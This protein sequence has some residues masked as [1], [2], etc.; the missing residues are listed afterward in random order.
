VLGKCGKKGNHF[1][2]KSKCDCGE[3][4][5]IAGPNLTSGNTK[6]CGCFRVEATIKRNFK[7]G[8]NTKTSA[9]Y[10][11][12]AGIKSRIYNK[13]NAKYGVYGGRGIKLCTRWERFENFLSDM[14]KKPEGMSIDRI[15]NNKGYYRKNCR[16]ATSKQQARNTSRT[17]RIMYKGKKKSLVDWCDELGLS[18]GIVSQ[19]INK[20]GWTVNR[21]FT[22]KRPPRSTS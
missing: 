14:G 6:S 16:W 19:R 3:I 13:K 15:D 20:L 9:E 5:H 4:V 21:A 11:S 8:H 1:I 2:W 18:Y 17:I 10:R 7:H 12:W 22:T